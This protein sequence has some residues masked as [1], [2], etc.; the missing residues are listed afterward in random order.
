MSFSKNLGQAF[1]ILVVGVGSACTRMNNNPALVS[2]LKQEIGKDYERSFDLGLIL[3]S[4]KDVR[5]FGSFPNYPQLTDVSHGKNSADVPSEYK[6]IFSELSDYLFGQGNRPFELRLCE[7]QCN[8]E[9]D[10]NKMIVYMDPTI[11]EQLA[12]H[13]H[14]YE[15]PNSILYF[16]MAH[17]LS[18]YIYERSVSISPQNLSPNG[19]KSRYEPSPIFSGDMSSFYEKVFLPHMMLSEFKHAEIDA[20]AY[21]IMKELGHEVSKDLPFFLR[22]SVKIHNT[23][24]RLVPVNELRIHKLEQLLDFHSK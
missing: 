9:I 23:D 20:F 22:E 15:N 16:V 21:V 19:N 4:L 1:L 14:K 10:N 17:E 12:S 5:E 3:S 7:G 2:T 11:L 8:S 24:P 18:H 6:V 13:S